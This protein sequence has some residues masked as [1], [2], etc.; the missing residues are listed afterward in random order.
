MTLRRTAALSAALPAVVLAVVLGAGIAVAEP[1]PVTA[2]PF[3]RHVRT[4]AQDMGFDG[5]RNPGTH[6]GA[7]PWHSGHHSGHHTG[8]HT[9]HHAGDHH[10]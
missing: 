2:E 4:C 8:H 1:S 6:R 7:S 9:G 3:G 5:T 10:C